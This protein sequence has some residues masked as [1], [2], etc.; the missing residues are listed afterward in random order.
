MGTHAPKLTHI[1]APRHSLQ[2]SIGT[3]NDTTQILVRDGHFKR[4]SLIGPIHKKNVK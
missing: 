1:L 3:S 4:L 2:K